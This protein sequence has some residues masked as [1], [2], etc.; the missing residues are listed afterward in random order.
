MPTGPDGL[1]KSQANKLLYKTKREQSM[2]QPQT[3]FLKKAKQWGT[4][5]SASFPIILCSIAKSKGDFVVFILFMQNH[6]RTSLEE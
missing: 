1:F 5:Q 3:I 6:G 2:T 4:F